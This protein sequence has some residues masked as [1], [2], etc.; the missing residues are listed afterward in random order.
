[1]Q[2]IAVMGAGAVGCFFGGMLARAGADVTL[3]AR[4]PQLEA[5][6][7]NGLFIDS[8]HFQQRV[9]VRAS[10]E[11]TAVR[12]AELVLFSV[13]TVDTET[14]AKSIAPHLSPGALILSLQN[15]VDNVA[16]ISAAAGLSA[17]ASVV[18]VAAS[19]P[20]PGRVRHAGRGDLVISNSPAEQVAAI[21]DTFVPAGVPCRLSGNLEGELWQKLTLNCCGNAVSALSRS[22][23]GPAVRNPLVRQVM[24]TALDEARAVAQASG[25]QLPDDG[26]ENS[27]NAMNLLENYGS[28]TSST[29]QDIARG[30]RTEMDS[31]NGYV[32]RRGA[33]LGVPTVVNR[34]LY[35]LVKLLEEKSLS[36]EHGRVG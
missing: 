27:A 33:E 11:P 30:R 4:G 15:G 10:A 34:T 8:V 26:P 28:A 2:R 19:L 23:Y 12:G 32:A 29:E 3:I 9:P 17:L 5:L 7:R 22:G 13:K 18:Y 24:Q 1:V 35:A 14:A 31:L 36:G 6:A 25:V 16:R 20:E 21:R